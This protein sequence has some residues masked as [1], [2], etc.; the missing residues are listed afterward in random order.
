MEKYTKLEHSFIWHT[1]NTHRERKRQRHNK[2][3]TIATTIIKF[4]R[5]IET[6]L[7]N[8]NVTEKKEAAPRKWNKIVVSRIKNY[9]Y[10]VTWPTAAAWKGSGEMSNIKS[11]DRKKDRHINEREKKLLKIFLLRTNSPFVFAIC[12]CRPVCC[13]VCLHQCLPLDHLVLLLCH[14]CCHYTATA[15]ATVIAVV[16]LLL[17]VVVVVSL[18]AMLFSLFLLDLFISL[19]RFPPISIYPHINW[20]S[21]AVYS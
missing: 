21:E 17:V 15:T 7:K 14:C 8:K 11:S 9:I 6:T 13:P 4:E 2:W 3:M 5:K 1:H 19:V 10:T 20:G 18:R 12:V 16:S